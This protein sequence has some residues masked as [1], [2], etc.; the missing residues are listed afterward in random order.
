[1]IVVVL[2]TEAM[3]FVTTSVIVYVPPVAIVGA[4]ADVLDVALLLVIDQAYTQPNCEPLDVTLKEQ[5]DPALSQPLFT[6]VGS[7]AF[8]GSVS[9]ALAIN[10]A[11]ALLSEEAA[12]V[13]VSRT[14]DPWVLKTLRSTE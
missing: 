7:G 4:K 8:R 3:A 10:G 14:F 2:V 5:G 11:Q 12:T 6:M 13:A 9:E 1:L